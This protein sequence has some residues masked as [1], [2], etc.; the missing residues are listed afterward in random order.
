MTPC[1]RPLNVARQT[2]WSRETQGDVPSGCGQVESRH[3]SRW[4]WQDLARLPGTA[5]HR[6]RPEV[7]RVGLLQR[8]DATV[9][10]RVLLEYFTVA[11]SA[12]MSCVRDDNS[13]R[14]PAR[15]EGGTRGLH[16]GG[17]AP[18]TSRVVTLEELAQ[19][20]RRRKPRSGAVPEGQL[21]VFAS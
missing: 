12:G 1:T 19:V 2:W 7:P 8:H 13:P 16:A 18:R 21:G 3:A 17:G 5:P 15:V 14:G 4:G 20:V 6:F 10:F 11:S 9:T